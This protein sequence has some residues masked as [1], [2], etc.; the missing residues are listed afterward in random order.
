MSDHTTVIS[1]LESLKGLK[2][3]EYRKA[4]N[5]LHRS[6]CRQAEE[7]WRKNNPDKCKM[8]EEKKKELKIRWRTSGACQRYKP[9]YY[10][11][12]ELA[13]MRNSRWSE[14]EDCIIMD[15]E[16]NDRK[17]SIQ[18]GR[19]IE[20]I[21]IRRSRLKRLNLMEDVERQISSVAESSFTQYAHE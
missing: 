1:T 7:K 19:S 14:V 18:I 3:I 15:R 4:W 5:K 16:A 6:R 21:Q 8:S 20:A 10:R 17:I 13:P 11:G 9:F 2:G 12:W